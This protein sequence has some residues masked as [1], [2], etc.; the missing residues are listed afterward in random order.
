MFSFQNEAINFITNGKVTVRVLAQLELIPVGQ[1]AFPNQFHENGW[2]MWLP[3]P[4]ITLLPYF[5]DC[6][7]KEFTRK[8]TEL[9]LE[10]KVRPNTFISLHK[11]GKATKRE[12]NEYYIINKRELEVKRRLEANGLQYPNCTRDVI[13]LYISLRLAHEENDQQGRSCLDM[14]I[15]PLHNIDEVLI[16]P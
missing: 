11:E 2:G 13:R 9:F 10:Q 4:N 14:L 5:S 6:I 12:S 16:N 3:M 8:E 1:C 7:A 15:R